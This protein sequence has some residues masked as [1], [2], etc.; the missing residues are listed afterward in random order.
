[1]YMVQKGKPS[2]W[3]FLALSTRKG[4]PLKLDASHPIF[5]SFLVQLA[6]AF[7][8]FGGREFKIKSALVKYIHLLRFKEEIEKR[9]Q[10]YALCMVYIHNYFDL[11]SCLS[12]CV[13][14]CLSSHS[15]I[16]NSYSCIILIQTYQ[17][18]KWQTSAS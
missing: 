17:Q 16:S 10:F 9:A 8:S 7:S 5:S 4:C 3:I 13:S 14:M 11:H 15:T 6:P 2:E 1:M 12:L 18:F